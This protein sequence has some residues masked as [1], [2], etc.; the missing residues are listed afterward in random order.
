[1]KICFFLQKNDT[2]TDTNDNYK[3]ICYYR[4]WDVMQKNHPHLTTFK[5]EL[6]Y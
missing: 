6:V 5:L 3:I 1:M 4:S 2:W